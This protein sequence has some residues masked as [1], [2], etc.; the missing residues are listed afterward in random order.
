[1]T[2]RGSHST[3]WPVLAMLLGGCAPATSSPSATP[4]KTIQLP[5]ATASVQA[6][7]ET[8]APPTRFTSPRLRKER[9][10]TAKTGALTIRHA[11][12]QWQLSTGLDSCP[13][14]DQLVQDRFLDDGPDN[15]D[16]WGQEY[17]VQCTE[18]TDVSVRS[19]GPD[20]RKGTADDIVVPSY[21][22]SGD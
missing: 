19:G 5:S 1:M 21:G 15:S 4:A 22:R 3:Q 7:S 11:V 2:R 9:V 6:A 18:E 10:E 13:S 16:P 14:V 17:S 8:Q 12:M 20:Q